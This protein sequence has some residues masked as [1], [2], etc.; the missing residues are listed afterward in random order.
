VE[1]VVLPEEETEKNDSPFT[2][3]NENNQEPSETG[4]N[5]EPIK[6]IPQKTKI[7][8][9]KLNNEPIKEEEEMENKLTSK[10]SSDESKSG[11]EEIKSISIIT[12]SNIIEDKEVPLGEIESPPP[13]VP[14]KSPKIQI[15]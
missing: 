6:E 11:S 2:E 14:P 15:K 8:N 13:I 10:I 7:K 5:Q 12:P 1:E 3:T 4:N 9:S